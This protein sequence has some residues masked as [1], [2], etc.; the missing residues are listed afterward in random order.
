MM[1]VAAVFLFWA[2]G[3]ANATK[4]TVVSNSSC[5][6]GEKCVTFRECLSNV[7]LCFTANTNVSFVEKLYRVQTTSN[8]DFHV[9]RDISNLIIVGNMSTIQCTH[10]VGFSFINITNFRIQSLKFDS[11]GGIMPEGIQ[12]HLYL[13]KLAESSFFMSNGSRVAILL[14]N[15]NQLVLENTGIHR[16]YGY[17]LIVVNSVGARISNSNF[18]YNNYRALD[19]YQGGIVNISCCFTSSSQTN[20]NGGNVVVINSDSVYPT[21]TMTSILN[22]VI[23]FGVNLDTQLNFNENYTYTAGGLSLFSAFYSEHIQIKFCTLAGN[24]GHHSG[25]AVNI[26]DNIYQWKCWFSAL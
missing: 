11:C 5:V 12:S 9:V 23:T 8:G 24:I 1:F 7:V 13:T 18:S 4:I 20:C 14:G 25:N 21:N 10:M 22:T 3:W 6:P 16:S 19:C 26:T 2:A 15:I 17:G